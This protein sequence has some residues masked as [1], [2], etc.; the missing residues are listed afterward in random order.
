MTS[1]IPTAS[2][3]IEIIL[4]R[5]YLKNGYADVQIVAALTEYDPE[6]QA[7]SL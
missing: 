2:R 7:D 3:P 6:R 5:Y 1:T 4:R